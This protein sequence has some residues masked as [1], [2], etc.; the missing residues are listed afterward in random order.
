MGFFGAPAKEKVKLPHRARGGKL[1]SACPV[2]GAG[3]CRCRAI[4]KADRAAAQK[5]NR[6]TTCGQR[7]ASGGT[8]HKTAPCD[9]DH[10]RH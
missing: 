1:T 5:H 10:A 8:C 6:P 9:R 3:T 7:F 2:C 4:A